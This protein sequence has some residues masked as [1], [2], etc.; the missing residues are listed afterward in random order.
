MSVVKPAARRP[1]LPAAVRPVLCLVLCAAAGAELRG[2]ETEM[3]AIRTAWE[4]RTAATRVAEIAWNRTS[5]SPQ[6]VQTTAAVALFDGEKFDLDLRIDGGRVPVHKR[7][8]YDGAASAEIGTA[9]GSRP[10]GNIADGRHAYG[11]DELAAFPVLLALRPLDFGEYAVRLGSAALLDGERYLGDVPCRVLE[12]EG[13][14]PFRYRYWLDPAR[15]YVV[16]RYESLING[17]ESVRQDISYENDEASGLPLPA[18]WKTVFFSDEGQPAY[19]AE[20]AVT[21]AVIGG[22]LPDDAFSITFPPGAD[23]IDERSGLQT[24]VLEPTTPAAVGGSGGVAV[25][26]AGG[27]STDGLGLWFW[28]GVAAAVVLVVVAFIYRTRRAN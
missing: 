13:E 21:R 20:N 19:T 14:A 10:Y 12:A 11:T 5:R 3:E 8:V 6:G 24:T 25:P 22:S 15:G 18:S 7:A 16:L 28:G 23:L 4:A 17:R 9:E 2:D 1:H 27:D 26:A